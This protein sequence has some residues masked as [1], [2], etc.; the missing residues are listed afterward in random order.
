MVCFFIGLKTV[1][2]AYWEP[3]KGECA[4]NIRWPVCYCVCVSV[5]VIYYNML[6]LLLFLNRERF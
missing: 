5:C 2:L 4:Q 1:F 6:L 3:L